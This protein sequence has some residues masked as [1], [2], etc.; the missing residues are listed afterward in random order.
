[1]ID[2][3]GLSLVS[4]IARR[5]SHQAPLLLM[6]VSRPIRTPDGRAGIEIWW[7]VFQTLSRTLPDSDITVKRSMSQNRASSSTSRTISPCS[8]GPVDSSRIRNRTIPPL[9]I[10]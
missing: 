9:A 3:R 8:P 5:C 7:S 6:C 10:G 2:H 1:M 4:S